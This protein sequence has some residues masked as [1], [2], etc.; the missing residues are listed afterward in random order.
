[1]G[2]CGPRKGQAEWKIF[3]SRGPCVHVHC[4]LW[5]HVHLRVMGEENDNVKWG[6][7]HISK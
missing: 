5:S 6:V 3:H 7:R 2:P 4:A 1:M